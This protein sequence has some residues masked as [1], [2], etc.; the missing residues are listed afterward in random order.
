MRIFFF[1]LQDGIFIFR[2]SNLSLF[3]LF[4]IILRIIY[5]QEQNTYIQN[6]TADFLQELREFLSPYLQ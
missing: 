6:P 5:K 3:F 4:Q 2:F 1:L